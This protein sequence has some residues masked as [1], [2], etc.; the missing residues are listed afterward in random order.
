[1]VRCERTRPLLLLPF[2]ALQ[3]F[4]LLAPPELFLRLL[5]WEAGGM[6]GRLDSP[7]RSKPS[8]SEEEEEEEEAAVES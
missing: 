5:D 1:M 6:E 8:S 3:S 4:E 7:P 2:V